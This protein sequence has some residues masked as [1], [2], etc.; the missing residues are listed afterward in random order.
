M[1]MITI[2]LITIIAGIIQGVTGFGSGIIMMM[3]LPM[4]FAL[5]QSAGISSAIGI[6][7]NLSMVYAYRKYINI[8]KIVLPAILYI[9]VCSIAIYF[10][11]MVN[12]V[13][14]KKVFGIFLVV[15]AIYYLFIQKEGKKKK[16]TLAISICCIVISAICDGLFGIG[17]PLMVLYFLA[18]THNTHEYLG[19][20][21]TFFFIN[22]S[23][24]TCFRI[25]NGILKVE[26][27]AIIG[28]GVIGIILGGLIGNKIVDKLDGV[29][30]R[31]LTYL[32]IGVS[33]LINLF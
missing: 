33:G 16:L 2:L 7:L 31:K 23:Y 10:S 24:N 9:V 25:A 4:L 1:E 3:V 18:Q 11:T 29:W 21:Q 32:M 15:L 12:Q 8:K 28:V 5:P 13:I 6:F 22:C 19:T 26:H 17:G 20:I 27:L 14:M 30:I